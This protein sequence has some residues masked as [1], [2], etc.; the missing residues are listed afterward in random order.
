MKA[1]LSICIS[2][3]FAASLFAFFILFEGNTDNL[4]K[5]WQEFA[6]NSETLPLAPYKSRVIEKSKLRIEE[7]NELI[8]LDQH[9]FWKGG[10]AKIIPLVDKNEIVQSFKIL[11]GGKGYSKSVDIRVKGAGG[12]RF[13]FGET[14]V[15]KGK[16]V[17]INLIQTSTWNLVPLAYANDENLPFSGTAKS[18]YPSGQIIEQIP[19]LSG[20][21]HGTVKKWNEY[22]IPVSSKDYVRGKKHGTHIFWFEFANDPDDF[23]PVKAKNG[24]IYPTLWIKLQEDAKKKFGEQ[25]GSHEA[26]EWITFT[27]RMKG[28]DFPVRLLEHW[29]DGHKHGLFEGFDEFGNKTFK[30]D[31]KMGLRIKHK[32]FDKTK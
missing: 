17:S 5:W 10:G 29:K 31:F 25:F 18:E 4:K 12:D 15:V 9:L 30:D 6:V 8:V 19:Y 28:G 13:Q 3:F 23:V 22:G 14:T 7:A 11:D 27:Y 26:N 20:R 2:A 24:E 1:F 21:V 16:I 32:I